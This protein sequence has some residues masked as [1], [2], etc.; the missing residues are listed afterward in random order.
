MVLTAVKYPLIGKGSIIEFVGKTYATYIYIFHIFIL[1][2]FSILNV[3][4]L[5]FPSFTL[6]FIVFILT[7]F[8]II[9]WQK[10][11]KKFF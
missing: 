1:K 6:P 11:S 7:L 4:F 5:G 9:I 10:C 2:M 3:K 8:F